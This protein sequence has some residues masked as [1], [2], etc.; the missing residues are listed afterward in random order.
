MDG[1]HIRRLGMENAGMRYFEPNKLYDEI[2]RWVAVALGI[3]FRWGQSNTRRIGMLSMPCDS[4]AAGLV[5]LGALRRDLERRTANH[6]DTHFDLL[7]KRCLK[8]DSSQI[9]NENSDWDLRHIDN[10]YWRFV[11]Y[12]TKTDAIVVED[13]K[14]RGIV[15]RK[16]KRVSNP[17][18]VCHRY[19]MRSSA[20]EWQLRGFPVPKSI[21]NVKSLDYFDYQNFPICAGDVLREN[22]S[23]SYEG[24]VLVGSGAARDSQYMQKFYS[25]GFSIDGRRLC[26]GDLLTLHQ[27]SQHIKRLRFLNERNEEIKELYPANLV[28]ADGINALLRAYEL[29]SDSD[30]IGVCS[31]DSTSEAI[32]Q[33]KDFLNDKARYY[34]DIDTSQYLADKTPE[35]ML[36]RVLQRKA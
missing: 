26:L 22:L 32:M 36:F 18:G 14:H 19:L 29:F 27:D 10:T 13:A 6:L 16:G 5:A 25:T 24:L 7:V 23:C 20:L 21:K 1:K 35:G 9:L 30:I 17:H 2:P 8:R 4:E 31:R 33:L 34:K 15:K 3:G 28:I 11:E 12:D